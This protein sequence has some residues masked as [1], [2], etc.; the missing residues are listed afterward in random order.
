MRIFTMIPL[1]IGQAEKAFFTPAISATP[2]LIMGKI[3]P[4]PIMDAAGILG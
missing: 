4:I 2:G 3:S 1:L